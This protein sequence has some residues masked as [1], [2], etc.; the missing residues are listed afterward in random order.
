ML[1]L[2]PQ[3]WNCASGPKHQPLTG[4]TVYYTAASQ[5]LPAHGR[6]LSPTA[7][8]LVGSVAQ[9]DYIATDVHAATCHPVDSITVAARDD[10][11]DDHSCRRTLL[12]FL[13]QQVPCRPLEMQHHQQVQQTNPATTISSE[14]MMN[15]LRELVIDRSLMQVIPTQ[16]F[17]L[18]GRY[19]LTQCKYYCY[20]NICVDNLERCVTLWFIWRPKLRADG[21][22]WMMAATSAPGGPAVTSSN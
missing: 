10:E 5:R 20:G 4:S 11:S 16:R 22:G 14:V 8:I 7:N 9:A 19:L 18:C 3:C 6:L 2:L 15:A 21:W 13:Q 12:R 17:C 1:L